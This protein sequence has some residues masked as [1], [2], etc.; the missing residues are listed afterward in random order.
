[1]RAT[2]IAATIGQAFALLLGLLGLFTNPFLT[3]IALFVWIG[4][5]QESIEVRLQEWLDGAPV[6]PVMLTDFRTLQPTDSLELR[7]G[8]FV[9]TSALGGKSALEGEEDQSAHP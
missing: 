1:M 3:L 5:S 4:A 6:S 7:E 8:I 2:T 9:I